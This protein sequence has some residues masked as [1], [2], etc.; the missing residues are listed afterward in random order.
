[1][2]VLPYLS[3]LL[4]F[5]LVLL[6]VLFIGNRIKNSLDKT[7]LGRVDAVAGA[8]LGILKYAFSISIIIW[9]FESFKL[10]WLDSITKDSVLYPWVASV[11]PG[12]SSFFGDFLPFFK[13][14]FR[15]F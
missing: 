10:D 9:I 1:T 2:K 3:F 8:V 6:L 4:I 12:V 15:L 13:E 7:F 11:A 14:T 5:G